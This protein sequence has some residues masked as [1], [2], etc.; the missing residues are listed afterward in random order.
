M[1]MV[2]RDGLGQSYTL[3]LGFLRQELS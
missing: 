2:A 1:M 3:R